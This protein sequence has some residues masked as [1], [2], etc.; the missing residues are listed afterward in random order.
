[1]AELPLEGDM[2]RF[3]LPTAI[4]PRYNGVGT[5]AQELDALKEVRPALP[6][7]SSSS[8]G[9]E[10]VPYGL[11]L[12]V[13]VE[14]PSR[15]LSVESPSHPI[16]FALDGDSPTKGRVTLATRETAL[17]RDF[18]LLVQQKDAHSPGLWVD[19]ERQAVMLTLYPKFAELEQKREFIFLRT[20]LPACFAF[21]LFFPF[22]INCVI[23]I[24]LFS[25]VFALCVQWT[26]RGACPDP[27][28][29]TPRP[30]FSS[31]FAACP[32]AADSTVRSHPHS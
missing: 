29:R 10:S 3:T 25:F 31:S 9:G 11:E 24:I 17:D 15:L 20:Q 8:S 16:R 22:K 27:A 19:S 23:L 6:S 32:R 28:S 12:D 26:A 4:A 18:V 7:S 2:V 21:I 13:A 1:V 30:R 14:M 5:T